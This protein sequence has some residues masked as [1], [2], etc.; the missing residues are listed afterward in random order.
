MILLMVNAVWQVLA[1]FRGVPQA[2]LACDGVGGYVDP[3]APGAVSNGSEDTFLKTTSPPMGPRHY[4]TGSLLFG[5]GSPQLRSFEIMR[6]IPRIA[7]DEL[8][9]EA[10]NV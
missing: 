9:Q 7:W 6:N 8:Y 5:V 3:M 10:D 2:K 1:G 4:L